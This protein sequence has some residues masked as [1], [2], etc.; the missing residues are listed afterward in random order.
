MDDD[1][2]EKLLRVAAKLK[3]QAPKKERKAKD[4]WEE[5]L[6]RDKQG[7]VEPEPRNVLAILLNDE[8]LAK[9]VRYDEFGRKLVV[10]KDLPWRPASF[11][12]SWRDEDDSCLRNY[13]S[14]RYQLN[15]RFAIEDSLS[16]ITLQNRFHPVRDWLNS[17]GTQWDGVRRVDRLLVD[18]LGAEDSPYVR[19]VT[20]Y[21]LLAAVKRIF[22]PGCKF[23]EMMVLSG[24][25]GIG[26]TLILSKLGGEWFS[27][28][29]KDVENKDSWQSMTGKW[30]IEIGEL[31]AKKRSDEDAMKNFLSKTEDVY[32]PAY[33][34]YAQSFPRQC[35]F[36]GTVN[37][38]EFLN[39][40]TG[41][42]R[43]LPIECKG[44]KQG[45]KVAN[46]TKETV[47]QIWSEV[48]LLYKSGVDVRL[49]QSIMAKAEEVREEY[50]SGN[51]DV[52]FIEE[53]LD[54][55]IPVN[56]QTMPIAQRRVWM[57][58]NENLD[59]VNLVQRTVTCVLEILH[60]MFNGEVKNKLIVQ[61][62][63]RSSK[64]WTRIK[65]QGGTA[66]FGEL[67][68]QRTFNRV[69]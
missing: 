27:N 59:E 5:R 51:D 26:K 24:A 40:A 32:R 15:G 47:E 11:S 10:S 28:S 8:A 7:R 6:S 36:I 4:G 55:K 2:R 16:Q 17:I 25:Q 44:I 57:S 50:T 14:L 34:R 29:F 39:D 23:D 69:L 22:E 30:L 33:G 3:S 46:M 12:S 53:Y 18:Y 19:A 54:R 43:Y 31:R 66:R 60:E 58:M 13:L 9:A 62:A 20:R 67:G 37:D 56:W 48:Y 35:V 64:K 61:R 52:A 49:P 45:S 65:G 63:L 1:E 68:V 21:V 42:R 38:D 41:G